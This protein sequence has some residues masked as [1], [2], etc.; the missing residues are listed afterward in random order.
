M[1]PN[2]YNHAWVVDLYVCRSSKVQTSSYMTQVL[3]FIAME[4]LTVY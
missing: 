4:D 1:Y 2:N 3:R